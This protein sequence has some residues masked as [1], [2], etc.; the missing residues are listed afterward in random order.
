MSTIE[1]PNRRSNIYSRFFEMTHAQSR[2]M[3]PSFVIIPET[4][5]N[6]ELKRNEKILAFGSLKAAS[7][8]NEPAPGSFTRSRKQTERTAYHRKVRELFSSE[9]ATP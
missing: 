5:F 6:R 8:L 4:E 2:A 1:V 9:K 3:L 7:Y